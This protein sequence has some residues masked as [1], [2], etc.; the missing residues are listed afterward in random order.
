MTGESPRVQS[1]QP[2]LTIGGYG[3]SSISALPASPTRPTP[4]TSRR[5]ADTE[6]HEPHTGPRLSSRIIVL[7][8][9]ITLVLPAACSNNSDATPEVVTGVI[10][11]VNWNEGRTEVRS[12]K[13]DAESD[14]YEVW[15]D[16]GVDYGFDLAH[17]EEHRDSHEPVKV[18]LHERNG[19]L[20]AQQ[21]DDT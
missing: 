16:D 2:C 5:C 4:V 18:S 1:A 12:F 19:R 15:I 20:F 21:I 10:T 13:M 7:V 9:S 3:H 11:E 8:S 6:P 17:L 14:D